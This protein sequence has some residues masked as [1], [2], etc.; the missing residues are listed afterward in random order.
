MIRMLVLGYVFAIRSERALCR[1]VQ[2]NFA[3]RYFCGLS[4]ED[5]DP[6]SFDMSGSARAT[7]SGTCLMRGY[8]SVGIEVRRRHWH[9]CSNYPT[10]RKFLRLS[11]VS[12]HGDCRF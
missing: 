3:Y 8:N 2:V 11:V 9:L 10:V 12:F 1:D 7:C 4:I 5:E 6:R